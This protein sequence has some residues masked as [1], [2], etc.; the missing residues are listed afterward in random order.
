M[1]KTFTILLCVIVYGLSAWVNYKSIQK[2][3]SKGGVFDKLKPNLIDVAFTVIPVANTVSAAI[4]IS[5]NIDTNSFFN[6]KK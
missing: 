4:I 3:Y 5:F 1:K 6:V 2:D